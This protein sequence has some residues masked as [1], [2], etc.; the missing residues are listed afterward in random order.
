MR[1]G[2]PMRQSSPISISG[3]V[4][5]A[6]HQRIP[7]TPPEIAAC[8]QRQQAAGAVS[9]ESRKLSV[10]RGETMTCIVILEVTAKKGAG[11][12]LVETFRALL[13][14]TRNK[15]GCQ[16][17]EV[18]T[19]LDNADNLVLVQRWAT[20]KHYENYLAWRQQRGDVDKL[21]EA[22][23]GQDRAD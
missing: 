16:G 20:R 12:Q 1:R 15:D 9:S 18:T 2:P 7:M 4:C 5:R 19:N 17:V 21:V 11:M 6:G 8:E 13:S 10:E 22:S 23:A 3:S 14:D